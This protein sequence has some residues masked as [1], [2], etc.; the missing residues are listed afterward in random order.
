M[1]Y[2]IYYIVLSYWLLAQLDF[3]YQHPHN[4]EAYLIFVTGTT[5]AACVKKLPGV[6]FY[7][8]NPKNWQFTV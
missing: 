7:R 5:G 2:I 6:N 3:I 1:S 4:K 8:F